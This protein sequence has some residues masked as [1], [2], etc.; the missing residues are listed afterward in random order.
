MN[1]TKQYLFLVS[2]LLVMLLP[3]AASGQTSTAI[4]GR[5]S[6]QTGAVVAKAQVKAH[7]E[8]TNQDLTTVTTATGDF[9]FPQLRPGL[10]DVS[11]TAAG[12]DTAIE[13]AVNLHLDA[14]ATVKLTLKPGSTQ[15]SV[16]VHA[17]EAQLDVTHASKGET[18]TQDELEQSPFNS[19]NPLMLANSAPAVTFQGTNVSGAS[20]VR[21]F[22]HQ[23]VNQFSVNGGLSDSND[24]Q[25]DGSPNNSI[26]FGA[27]DIGTVP[28]TASVQEMK[29]I[30]NPYDAQYGH[31]GGG[32]FDIVTKYGGN[33]LH[34]Q[35][36]DNIR[37]NWLDANNEVADSQSLAKASDNRNQYGL[38]LDGPVAIPHLY[39]GHDK[40]FFALQVERYNE[41]DPQTGV[42]SV[43][44]FSPGSTTQTVADT[45]DFGGAYYLG[46]ANAHLP[47]NIYNPFSITTPYDW[48]DPRTQFTG[49]VLTAGLID[50]TA[51]KILSYLPKPNRTTPNNL[52]WG[53]DNYAW[54]QGATL[55]YDS[56]TIRLDR[57]FTEKDK[58]YIRFNWTKNWQNNADAQ[59]FDSLPG[60]I[61][62][63]VDPLVFQTHFFIADWQHAF[64]ANSLFD[65]HLSYQRFAYNQN[66]GPSPFDLSKIGLSGLDS[67]VTEQVFPQISIGG[68]G[69]ITEF[70]NNADNGGNKLT[71]SNTIAAMPMWTYIHGAH[72]IKVGVDYR[73]QRSSSYYGGAASGEFNAGN[74]YTQ[75]YGSCLGCIAGQGSGL[76]TFM[77]GVM[78]GGSMHI[79]V[80]QLFTYPYA[81]PFFQDDWKLTPKLTVNLGLRWDIQGAPTESGNKIVGAFDTTSEN[82][83]NSIVVATGKLPAG[84]SLMGGMTYAGVSGESR[85]LY[86]TNRFLVQP[87][88]GFNYALNNKT[89]VR[90]GI[91]ST[92]AQ[93][94]GQGYSQGFTADTS[95]VSSTT[96]GTTVDGNLIS[97][98]F[99]VVAKPAGASRG[100]ESS[101]GNNFNAVN[102]NFKVPAVLNYSFGV[103]RQVG[104][105]TSVDVSYVGNRGLNMDSSDNIN[106]ISA[107]Y[108]A[109]CNLEM[110]AT[111]ARYEN[112]VHDTR[113]TNP[114]YVTNPF[115][116][117]DAFSPANTGNLNNYYWAGQLDSSVM[118]RPYPEFGDITQTQ[119]NDG[120]T[121]YDSL[122]AV[123][124]HHWRDAL[125]FHGNFVWSK[126]MNDGWLND[127]V[128][129]VRQHYLDRTDRRWRWAANADWHVPVGRGRTFLGNSNR[130]V[131][132]AIGGWV[133]GAIY[134]Y[135]AGTPAP[136]DRGG[137]GDGLEVVHTQHY[138]VHERTET[139]S[140]LRGSSKCVGWYDPNPAVNDAGGLSAGNAPYTLSD[141]VSNDYAGCAVNTTGTGHVYDF[142]V[143]PAF[144]V[145]Q[146]VSDNGVRNPNGQNLDM[147]VSKSFP[148]WETMKLQVRFEGYNVMNHPSYQG[149]DYWS[150]AWD[151]HFGTIN[152]YYDG[153]SNIPRNVQLSA[154]IVW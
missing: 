62:R 63:A 92:Y 119:Q 153:Q 43:P 27:R 113:A 138:G 148:V 86:N 28:P 114:N 9:T 25:M 129:R 132:S 44:E 49:N 150:D 95:Y 104:Q 78:D 21:P 71:I 40:T 33:Q 74:W 11:A 115:A 118:T 143:R 83:V 139:Q 100:L 61:G 116:G 10:Y 110:G 15:E 20:W 125:T 146:N 147:S 91:G 117:I 19:G 72:T 144:A 90:G 16:T 68:F 105:H 48:W 120:N 130:I 76:A 81:A 77:L 34:G 60:P 8:L 152:K 18:F 121:E 149:V 6:D 134:T 39:N 51:Q 47:V 127:T 122:Q 141:T 64:G 137:P 97:N 29:F 101:L 131:D 80:R 96:N 59:T 93:F 82:P 31:T 123:V 94:T 32:I 84:I 45:G 41:K 5:V 37:R 7:N 88:V 12:F 26:T 30:Q 109:S 66:Q 126:Q 35:V 4:T 145:V 73:M 24:F 112:C 85:T 1:R 23:S 111:A 151:S 22:D 154:K 108:A 53:E 124:S 13:T 17:D 89:V 99:P 38:E 142:I 79:G 46:A 42:A 65:L 107:G 136:M 56:A 102:P 87:R 67:N 69:G 128:Y 54:S 2:F 58:T 55:P 3:F 57:N 75:Q 106:H 140:V 103:E 135:E 36:Y 52:Q 133:I 70:G 50:N 14:V 98:P